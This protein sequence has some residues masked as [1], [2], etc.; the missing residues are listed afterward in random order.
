MAGLKRSFL[1]ARRGIGLVE[2]AIVL[3]IIG[4][5]LTIGAGLF[6]VLVKN[7]KFVE[8]REVVLSLRDAII[9]YV[10]TR[11]KLPCDGTETCSSP[12]K[13]YSELARAVDSW[14][15]PLLYAYW[16]QLRDTSDLCAETGTG[17]TV[18]LCGGDPACSSPLQVISDVAFIVLSTGENRN[19]QTAGAGRMTTTT[20]VN[21]YDYGTQADDDTSDGDASQ[22]GYDDIVEYVTLYQLKEKLCEGTTQCVHG[23]TPITVFNN[24]GGDRCFNGTL[25]GNGVGYQV[26][27]GDSVTVRFTIFSFCVGNDGSFTYT[28]AVNADAD[29]DCQVNYDGGGNLSDR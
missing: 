11:G 13:R 16:G 3:L 1:M 22:E 12:Q 2:I 21:I 9:G 29:G 28:D 23:T 17:L 27:P 18:R 8:S 20:T 7:T 10:L 24:T 26:N 15:L 25:V 4:I 19:K 14:G 5:L 6:K